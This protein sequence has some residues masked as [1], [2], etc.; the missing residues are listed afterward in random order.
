MNTYLERSSRFV[1]IT[2]CSPCETP[3]WTTRARNL[4]KK[5]ALGEWAVSLIVQA[6]AGGMLDTWIGYE[7][8]I[9]ESLLGFAPFK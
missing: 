6:E 1:S 2:D 7:L 8:P 4:P 9:T 3:T 5:P